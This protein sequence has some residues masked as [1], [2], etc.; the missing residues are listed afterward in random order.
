MAQFIV[1]FAAGVYIGT[2][3]NCKPGI[4]FASDTLEQYCPKREYNDHYVPINNEPIPKE[5]PKVEEEK[6]SIEL[7]SALKKFF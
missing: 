6:K 2:Y 4:K 7:T 3:Y 1:G 5:E